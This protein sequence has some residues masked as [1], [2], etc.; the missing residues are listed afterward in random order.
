MEI[1]ENEKNAITECYNRLYKCSTPSADFNKLLEKA[2]ED[3][4]GNKIIDYNKYE[5]DENSF[6]TILEDIIKEYKIIPRYRANA[7]AN[8]IYLGASPKFKQ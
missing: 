5:I 2:K 4:N 8:H 7:F 6:D 1:T 3:E